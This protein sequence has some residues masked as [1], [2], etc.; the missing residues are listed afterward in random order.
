MHLLQDLDAL[1]KGHRRL[2]AEQSSCQTVVGE[3]FFRLT[4]P[5]FDKHRTAADHIGDFEHAII[6]P[7]ANIDDGT[8]NPYRAFGQ[9][10]PKSGW[11]SC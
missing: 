4:L 1:L 6:R 7:R 2:P 9:P 10:R 8:Q 11:K 5:L 3:G